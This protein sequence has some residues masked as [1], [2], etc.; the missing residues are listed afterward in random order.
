LAPRS[1][2]PARSRPG[3]GKRRR[4]A[5][6][7]AA[8]EANPGAAPGATSAPASDLAPG[9]ED[10]A[11]RAARLGVTAERVLQEYARIAFADLSHFFEWGPEGI[12]VKASETLSDADVAAV[13]EITASGGAYRVK[14]YDKKAALDAIARHLGMFAAPARRRDDAVTPDA[15]ED[16]REVLARRLARLAAG[17]AAQ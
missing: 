3:P 4:G 10:I 7:A 16:A 5:E 14:L 2:R 8:E 1:A 12:V 11:E 17:G 9:L 13:S 6:P 15:A